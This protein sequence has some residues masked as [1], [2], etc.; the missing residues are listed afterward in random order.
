MTMKWYNRD[1]TKYLDLSKVSFFEYTP[2][3]SSY[4][5]HNYSRLD[6][7]VGG[8]DVMLFKDEADEVYKILTYKEK[9]LLQG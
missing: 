2:E 4:F 9:Q 6:L 8:V 7:G 3:R 1:K 5:S